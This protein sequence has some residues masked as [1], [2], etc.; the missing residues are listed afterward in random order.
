MTLNWYSEIDNLFDAAFSR[1]DVEMV[2]LLL[3]NFYP[4]MD[5]QNVESL[6]RKVDRSAGSFSVKMSEV[7]RAYMGMSE[8]AALNYLHSRLEDPSLDRTDL[9]VA[10][11]SLGDSY[12]VAIAAAISSGDDECISAIFAEHGEKPVSVK[13]AKGSRGA[14]INNVSYTRTFHMREAS[15]D[16]V[17]KYLNLAHRIGLL[18]EQDSDCFA[19]YYPFN[20]Y[21]IRAIEETPI[22]QYPR[23]PFVREGKIEQPELLIAMLEML[24]QHPGAAKL[25][26]RIPVWFN[27]DAGNVSTSAQRFEKVHT[28]DQFMG[29]NNSRHIERSYRPD[30]YQTLP[31]NSLIHAYHNDPENS[32]SLMRSITNL[33]MGLAGVVEEE[34]QEYRKDQMLLNMLLPASQRFGFLDNESVGLSVVN[35]EDLS[36]MQMGS[37]NVH[38][39]EL[40][41]RAVRSMVTVKSIPAFCSVSNYDELDKLSVGIKNASRYTGLFIPEMTNDIEFKDKIL[42]HFGEELFKEL[43]SSGWSN[44]SGKDHAF[45]QREFNLVCDNSIE[46][47]R[48][49]VIM[50]MFKS[51]YRFEDKTPVRISWNLKKEPEIV[52]TLVAM[53]YW[54]DNSVSKPAD[55][56]DGLKALVRKPDNLALRAYLLNA[57]A[58]AICKVAK[59]EPQW[60][61]VAQLFIDQPDIIAHYAPAKIKREVLSHGFDL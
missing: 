51:G 57:G 22:S 32:S 43:A 47:E 5:L 54:P 30:L 40:A 1:D 29:D 28:W 50:E 21:S 37:T 56:F 9:T 45:L 35:V 38:E 17:L 7:F 15:V 8:E 13:F 27:K 48:E 39:I 42:N 33:S 20:S 58:E 14:F 6:K 11:K 61:I 46:I 18:K 41:R 34:T 25:Y 4:I 49:W 2:K 55:I 16:D 19:R 36:L 52:N 3:S 60:N 26:Q 59:T 10:V 31:L 44:Y 23:L 53:N 12:G 24:D